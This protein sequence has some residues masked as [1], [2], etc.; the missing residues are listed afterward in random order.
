MCPHLLI[1]LSG[2][3]IIRR[4]TRTMREFVCRLS[5]LATYS[6]ISKQ[7]GYFLFVVLFCFFYDDTMANGKMQF[8]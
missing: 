4:K 5:V 8:L 3:G 6:F 1:P 7:I 2:N